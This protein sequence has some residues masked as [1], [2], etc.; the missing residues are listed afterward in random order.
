MEST[1]MQT[2]SQGFCARAV[3]KVEQPPRIKVHVQIAVLA[4]IKSFPMPRIITAK[5]VSVARNLST[6][7]PRVR[8]AITVCTKQKN[9]RAQSIIRASTARKGRSTFPGTNR[10]GTVRQEEYNQAIPSRMRLASPVRLAP[11]PKPA[12]CPSYPKT[13]CVART[14]CCYQNYR[15][16]IGS[17]GTSTDLIFQAVQLT[18]YL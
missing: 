4:C 13:K 17:A 5:N 12:P 11:Y 2:M 9:R 10:A 8:S 3:Q 18:S 7:R 16:W 6:R 14:P 15:A 1:K